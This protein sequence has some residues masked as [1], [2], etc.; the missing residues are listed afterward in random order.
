MKKIVNHAKSHKEAEK[1]DIN[2][3]IQ[4]T[5]AERQPIAAEL[6][7]RFYGTDVPDVREAHS[8]I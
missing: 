5:P 8:N 3:Q 4:L 6:K 1:W 7:K 2:Q